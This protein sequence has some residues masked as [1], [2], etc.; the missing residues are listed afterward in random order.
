MGL[1]RWCEFIGRMMNPGFAGI[2]VMS[3]FVVLIVMDAVS[4]RDD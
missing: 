3:M 2:A 1:S 4:Q